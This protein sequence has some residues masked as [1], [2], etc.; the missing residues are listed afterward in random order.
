MIAEPLYFG[1]HEHLFGMFHPGHGA[2]GHAVVICPPMLNEYMRSH[3]ALRRVAMSLATEGYDVLRFDFSGQGN[4]LGEPKEGGCEA[5]RADIEDALKEVADL[6]GATR[7]SLMAVRFSCS[8]AAVVSQRRRLARFVC[9][10]PVFRG[11]VWAEALEHVRAARLADG[12]LAENE[13]MGQVMSPAF[14]A[15]VRAH[16]AMPKAGLPIAIVRTD[17]AAEIVPE[18][19]VEEVAFDCGWAALTSQVLYAHQV[20]EQL[21]KSVR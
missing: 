6:S 8:L 21:C 4:S 14:I 5:W 7:V 3:Y 10:D 11:A 1:R 9:W 19:S 16:E 20:I 2:K 15:E 18:A 13:Y 17:D 12:G